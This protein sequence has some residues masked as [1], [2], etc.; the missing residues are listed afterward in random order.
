MFMFMLFFL[1]NSFK[2]Y[3]WYCVILHHELATHKLRLKTDF[4]LVILYRNHFFS[5]SFV[6]IIFASTT[7]IYC[8]VWLIV[9]HLASFFSRSLF[10]VVALPPFLLVPFIALGIS[11]YSRIPSERQKWQR[12]SKQ[13]KEKWFSEMRCETIFLQNYYGF[14]FN[15]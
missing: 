15:N 7:S 4:Q 9:C 1:Y 10:A 6:V 14:A 11:E 3:K 8:V 13:K 2:W 5:F 12:A